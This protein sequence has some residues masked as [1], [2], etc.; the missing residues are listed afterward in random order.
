MES[1]TSKTRIKQYAYFHSTCIIIIKNHKTYIKNLE[2][3]KI[4]KDNLW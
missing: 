4:I 3:K 2:T 1:S